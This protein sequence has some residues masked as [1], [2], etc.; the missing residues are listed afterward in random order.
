MS[1][2]GRPDRVDDTRDEGCHV[3][4]EGPA[5]RPGVRGVA[6]LAR[7]PA[8]VRQL[9]HRRGGRDNS[10]LIV[11]E[12]YGNRLTAFDIEA[13]GGLANRRVWADLGDGYPDGICL[14]AEGALWYGDVA[15]TRCVRVREGGEVL[16]TIDLDRGC[17]ACMLGGDDRRTL[18][19]L[20]A[21]FRGMEHLDD[22]GRTGRLLTVDAPAPGVGWP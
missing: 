17:F 18:Y 11:A 2:S 8:L 15:N 4:A 10:T 7:G 22:P 13:D 3:G 16:Q 21:H 9:G 1:M 6:A 19:M 12:S 20:A 14:D 5:G